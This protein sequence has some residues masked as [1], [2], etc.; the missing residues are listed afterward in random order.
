MVGT[1]SP[2]VCTACRLAVAPALPQAH[3]FWACCRASPPPVGHL[4][5][6]NHID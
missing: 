4:Q 3:I 2:F 6:T 1:I 5:S